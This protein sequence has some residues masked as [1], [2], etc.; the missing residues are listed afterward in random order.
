MHQQLQCHQQVPKRR[1]STSIN[2][3]VVMQIQNRSDNPEIHLVSMLMIQ[4]C[5][6][7]LNISTCGCILCMHDSQKVR[8]FPAG[9]DV[10]ADPSCLCLPCL[11][12]LP[13]HHGFQQVPTT[14]TYTHMDFARTIMSQNTIFMHITMYDN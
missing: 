4:I 1:E 10:H 14:H 9:Q 11:Q 13:S 5:V 6:V 7:G 3:T 2:D 8:A 12:Q